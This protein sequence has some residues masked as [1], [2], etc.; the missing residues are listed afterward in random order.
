MSAMTSSVFALRRMVKASKNHKDEALGY[1]VFSVM[2]FACAHIFSDRLFSSTITLSAACQCLG[3]VLLRLKVRKQRGAQGISVKTLQLYA[4]SL[5]CRLYS[6]LQYNGYLPVDR[7]GD[8]LYQL[9]DVVAL[10]V[11]AGL[12]HTIATKHSD[13][14]MADLDTCKISWFFVGCFILSLF[15]HPHLN[16]SL[17]PDLAWTLALYVETIAMVPQL[18]LMTKQGGE[19]EALGGHYIACIFVS[20]VVMMIFWV[21]SYHELTPKGSDFNLPGLGVMG[22]QI[23]QCV[24]LADFMYLYVKS[25]RYNTKLVLP[26]T[27]AI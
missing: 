9:V 27:F 4:V 13:T 26:E 10:A 24:L 7:S 5:C 2:A 20:R 16:N 6:T 3:F 25:V 18:W 23:L 8:W 15:V 11:V 17:I 12:L 14:Y 1:F 19:V 22:T 21:H